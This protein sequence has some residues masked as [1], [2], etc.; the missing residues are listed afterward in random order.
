MA[1][2]IQQMPACAGLVGAAG[3]KA[4]AGRRLHA[5]W[6]A[7]RLP[8]PGSGVVRRLSAGSGACCNYGFLTAKE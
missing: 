4:L 8:N 5:A 6:A 1:V 3:L 7:G 2:T